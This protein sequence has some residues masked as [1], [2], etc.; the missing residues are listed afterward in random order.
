MKKN[1]PR[2]L[3]SLLLR[4]NRRFYPITRINPQSYEEISSSQEY[5]A[6]IYKDLDLI[7]KKQSIVKFTNRYLKENESLFQDLKSLEEF[8]S[9]LKALKKIKETDFSPI[10]RHPSTPKE[11]ALKESI[12]DEVVSK[13]SNTLNPEIEYVI[14]LDSG[15]ANIL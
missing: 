15:Q 13:W 11:Q 2:I 10:P 3:E 4:F 9:Y 8:E 12:I 14:E 5:Q 7:K 6:F 1:K